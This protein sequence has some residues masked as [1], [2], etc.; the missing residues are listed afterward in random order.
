MTVVQP[1][2]HLQRDPRGWS[3]DAQARCYAS[4]SKF[5]IGTI[6]LNGGCNNLAVGDA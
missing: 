4:Q 5:C 2:H 1:A 6:T 3:I